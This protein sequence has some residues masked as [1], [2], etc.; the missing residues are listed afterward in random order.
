MINNRKHTT[1]YLCYM[2]RC[3]FK[4]SREVL[5]QVCEGKNAVIGVPERKMT[6]LRRFSR[7]ISKERKD[8]FLPANSHD[9]HEEI[10]PMSALVINLSYELHAHEYQITK[11]RNFTGHRVS[12]LCLCKAMHSIHIPFLELGVLQ[13]D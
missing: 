4:G 12:Q 1:V 6:P 8:F 10:L 13:T 9:N 5:Q 3:N 7:G 11:R 2:W